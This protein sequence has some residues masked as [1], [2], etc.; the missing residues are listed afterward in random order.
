MSDDIYTNDPEYIATQLEII[1]PPRL[2]PPSVWFAEHPEERR[3]GG[4]GGGRGGGERARGGSRGGGP[5]RV[6]G[7]G[8]GRD[9]SFHPYGDR[10][11]SG[12]H[13]DEFRG[14]QYQQPQQ[15]PSRY[16]GGWLS[17]PNQSNQPG[18][19]HGNDIGNVHTQPADPLQRPPNDFSDLPPIWTYDGPTPQPASVPS[20]ALPTVPAP[21][22]LPEVPLSRLTWFERTNAVKVESRLEGL[23]MKEE[24][25]GIVNYGRYSEEDLVTELMKSKILLT[26]LPPA[27]YLPARAKANPYELVG[28][29]GFTNRAA[30]K[31][32]EL[33]WIL[34]G[35]IS[36][37]RSSQSKGVWTWLDLCGG[38]GGFSEYLLWR[39]R[40]LNLPTLGIATT[41]KSAS[42]FESQNSS[43]ETTSGDL[44]LQPT[45]FHPIARRAAEDGQWEVFYGSDGSG[46]I[47]RAENVRSVSDHV[48]AK[49]AC[50]G[51][52]NVVIADGAFEVPDG[53][54]N[55]QEALHRRLFLCEAATAVACLKPGGTFLLKVFDTIHPTTVSLLYILS[56]LFS[57][58]AMLKPASS[59]PANSERY[60]VGKGFTGAHRT[61]V[62]EHLLKCSDRI[63]ELKGTDK[64]VYELCEGPDEEFGDWIEGRNMRFAMEQTSALQALF[65]HVEDP[66]TDSALDQTA[67]ATLAAKEWGIDSVV[68]GP[69]QNSH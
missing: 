69:Q 58:I 10:G 14:S 63:G 17:Q 18:H 61:A 27:T 30:V 12:R 46:D 29:T 53:R 50:A 1:A 64:D 19:L 36:G 28:R 48:K 23:K 21:V 33:D 3:P 35:A 4:G 45:T 13:S 2:T 42:N 6:D 62:I 65:A 24:K 68:S 51:G 57:E 22:A 43:S 25:A 8:R 66:R 40:S 44:D 5:S 34:D 59:R 16:T 20:A 15:Q 52:V 11:G 54:E 7:G 67:I 37:T 41:L 49:G 32:A 39:R 31:L 60:F 26:P 55:D 9:R 38:P 56:L 47:T